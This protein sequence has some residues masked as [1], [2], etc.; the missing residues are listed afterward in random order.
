MGSR[1]FGAL[2]ANSAQ[3]CLLCMHGKEV[4]I[5]EAEITN[6]VHSV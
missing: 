3:M 6:Y 4:I 5:A 1:N 2:F